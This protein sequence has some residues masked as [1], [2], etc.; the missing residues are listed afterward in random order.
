MSTRLLT[1]IAIASAG[2]LVCAAYVPADERPPVPARI[3]HHSPPAVSTN[4]DFSAKLEFRIIHPEE[5]PVFFTYSTGGE[6]AINHD[7]SE[8]NHEHSMQ[9][10]GTL[11]AGDDN[12]RLLLRY[13]V[14]AHHAD[15]NEGFEAVHGA[16]GSALLTPGET[17]TLTL[18]GDAPLQLTVTRED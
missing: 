2:A 7:I 11:S 6:F 3:L 17:L 16:S 8:P 15:L 9:I 13:D 1:V 5:S 14:Q 4:L 12:G 10:E 18:L